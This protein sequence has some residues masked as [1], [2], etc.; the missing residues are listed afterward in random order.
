[1]SRK[2][3]VAVWRDAVREST[4]PTT[5]K[6]V[7]WCLSTYMNGQCLAWPSVDTLAA[8]SS[9][10]DRATS[11]ALRVL[12]SA[13][14]LQ[15]DWS[16]GGRSRTHRFVA[17]LPET[18]NEV[19]LSEWET[20]KRTTRKGEPDALNPERRSPESV[21]SAESGALARGAR[22]EGSPA[23]RAVMVDCFT[24]GE[25]KPGGEDDVVCFDCQAA[26]AA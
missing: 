10:S 18:A 2:P 19:R 22:P 12:E 23:Q 25:S 8:G 24:C 11:K 26:E 17:C 14:F 21:E 16:E 15:V 3:L 7:A 13:G 6:T 9:L 5:A 4:L 20:A 1:V